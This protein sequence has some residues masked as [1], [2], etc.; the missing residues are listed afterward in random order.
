[1]EPSGDLSLAPASLPFTVASSRATFF[2]LPL[3]SLVARIGRGLGLGMRNW[4]LSQIG[5]RGVDEKAK[6]V[7]QVTYF[8]PCLVLPQFSKNCYSTYHIECLRPVHRA[9]NVDEKKN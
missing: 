4:E 5:G 8:S 3:C 7:G 2:L 9:L 6:K 1:M